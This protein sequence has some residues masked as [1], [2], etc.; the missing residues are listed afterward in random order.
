MLMKKKSD[1]FLVLLIIAH[2]FI[3]IL[4]LG[5]FTGFFA[6]F[7]TGYFIHFTGF[8]FLSFVLSVFLMQ[9]GFSLSKSLI[10]SWIY[11][12][13]FSIIF[14]YF[15]TLF[16]RNFNPLG[17]ISG[18]IGSSVYCCLA[19]ILFENKKIMEKILKF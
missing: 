1:L 13:I 19:L 17:I 11:I 12:L 2:I 15:Q 16:Q 4:G 3:F 5:H 9:K 10:A 18:V 14:E 6:K 8:F 7:T